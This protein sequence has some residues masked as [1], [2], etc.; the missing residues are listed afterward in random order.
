MALPVY[1]RI[2][3]KKHIAMLA[4]LCGLVYFTSYVTRIN[5]K[6]VTSAVMETDNLPMTLASLP[7]TGLFITY[8]VGQLI[9]GVLG[10]RIRPKYLMCAGLLLA[11]VTNVLMPLSADTVFRVTV[12]CINGFGQALMWPP[13]VKIMTGYLSA[14]DYLHAILKTSWGSQAGIFVVY[15][16]APLILAL[17]SSWHNVFYISALIGILGALL[18]IFGLGYI[19]R[20]A[21]KYGAENPNDES[22]EKP[23][24]PGTAIFPKGFAFIFGMLVFSNVLQG[25]LRDGVDAWMPTYV[26]QAF[27]LSDSSSILTAVILP[28]FGLA[29]Y[30][31][32]AFIAEHVIHND[33]LGAA[34]FFALCGTSSLALAFVSGAEFAGS[35]AFTV[36]FFALISGSMHGA[37]IILTSFIVRRFKK[38][39]NV[40]TI[41]GVLNFG[42]YVGAAISIYAF[43]ALR[44]SIGWTGTIFSWVI[45]AAVGLAVC[46]VIAKPFWRI[47][48]D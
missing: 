31:L 18:V 28:V 33:A 27:G 12:W 3:D 6:A 19:E 11:S 23:G 25:S 15:L 47:V 14:D 42:T 34:F 7:S 45:I 9:S 21:E 24:A 44:E 1:K 26:K 46:L 35:L 40:S 32:A 5:Y 29:T 36:L 48:K 38:F 22:G 39:G 43:A 30:Q 20:Y 4:Y 10:D 37:N 41:S 8:G 17:T 2:S 16:G 13:I